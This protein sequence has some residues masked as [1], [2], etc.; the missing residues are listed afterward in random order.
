MTCLYCEY[1]FCWICGGP[2]TPGHFMRFNPMGCGAG[3]YSE[4]RHFCVRVLLKVLYILAFLVLFPLMLIFLIPCYFGYTGTTATYGF[5]MQCSHRDDQYYRVQRT[6][7]QELSIKIASGLL[8]LIS[9]AASFLFGFAINLIVAPV[10]LVIFVFCMMPYFFFIEC[11][12]AFNVN[13]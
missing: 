9:G 3:F 2:Y 8:A 5:V 6:R 4:R 10:F 12:Q 11:T 7:C 13:S 1:E